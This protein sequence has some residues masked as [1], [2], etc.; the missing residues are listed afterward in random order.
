MCPFD[1]VQPT[2]KWSRS[3]RIMEG[4]YNAVAYIENKNPIEGTKQ[5]AYTVTLLD[6]SGATIA[7]RRGE[8]FLPPDSEYPIFEGRIETGGRI[9]AQTLLVLEPVTKWERFTDDRST[10]TVND[11]ALYGVDS[12]PR[13]EA[14]LYNTTLDDKRDVEIV[15]TIFDKSGTALTA[16]RTVVPLFESRTEK[17][18]VFTWPEP[19]AKTLRSCETPSDVMMAVDLSGSMDEDGGNPPE[20]ITSA[21]RA[22]ASFVSRLGAGDQ[23]GLA[24]FATNGALV[25]TL[26]NDKTSVGASI[27]ALTI[28]PKEQR[29]GTNAGDAISFATEEFASPRHSRDA[30]KVLVLFTDGKT[31]MPDPDPEGYALRAAERAKQSGI[32]IY[33]IGLGS[34][35]NQSFLGSVASDPSQR[36]LAADT[37]SLDQIYRSISTAICEEG[38][39]VI[40]IVPKIIGDLNDDQPGF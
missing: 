34:G 17:R 20:P 3:F 24:T 14:T 28:D 7:T 4:V 2:V 29:G 39:A 15:A 12:K 21:V 13:L 9:P 27:T 31:N 26:T 11:R 35:V 1:V 5:L 33:T 40:H 36:Y 8:T 25:R 30:R 6:A 22:A 16:S 10:F 23:A 32:S 37:R 18:V 38:P 19:I